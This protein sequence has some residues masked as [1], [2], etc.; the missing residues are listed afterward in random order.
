[1]YCA[2][3]VDALYA[4]CLGCG[5]ASHVACLAEWH[6]AGER[7]CPAGDECCCLEEACNGQVES[8][9]ALRAA[10]AIAEAAGKRSSAGNGISGLGRA[11]RTSVPARLGVG[12]EGDAGAGEEVDKGHRA[13]SLYGKDEQD[14]K[15]GGNEE[16]IDREDWESVASSHG[17]PSAGMQ[18]S[19]SGKPAVYGDQPVSAARLSL[20]NRLKKSL[21]EGRPGALRRKSGGVGGWKRSAGLG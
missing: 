17:I 13:A 1:V 6:A 14:D 12:Y 10:V 3:P 2:E 15:N 16:G 5:C 7:E 9:S 20:G 19:G 18:S 4:A 21:G 8:W 11:R